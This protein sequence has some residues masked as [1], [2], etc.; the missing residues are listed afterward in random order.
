M[1]TIDV[2]KSELS[3]ETTQVLPI[4]CPGYCDA[5]HRSAHRDHGLWSLKTR[6]EM[7][8]HPY[9]LPIPPHWET[10][11]RS[12]HAFVLEH[13][14]Q[15]PHCYGGVDSW[16]VG[17]FCSLA[18]YVFARME[19]RGKDLAFNFLTWGSCSDHCRDHAGLSRHPRDETDR[20]SPGGHPG[21]DRLWDIWNP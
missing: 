12:G 1:A 13:A 5:D 4:P 8:L 10:L 15:Q 2:R 16:R 17:L 20:Y 19:F 21:T 14:A 3:K 6:G 18:A 9:T 7:F 11:A